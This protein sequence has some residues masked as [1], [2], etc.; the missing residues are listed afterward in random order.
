MRILILKPSSLGDIVCS[1]PVAQSIREQMPSAEISWVVKTRFSEILKRCSTVNG[2]ILE[3]Q[4]APGVK[5]L[6][7]IRT[8]MK[9]LRNRH[10]DV[11]LDFQGLL[12]TGLMT[13]SVNSP[14][15]VGSVEAREGSRLAYNRVV[16]LPSNGRESHAIEKLLQFL[17][18]IG[19]KPELRS[20]IDIEG[21]PL[22]GEAFCASLDGPI[23]MI[24]NSRG[25]HKEWKGFEELTTRLVN[26][27]NCPIVVWD[28]HIRWNTPP[29]THPERFVN[30][31]QR[32]SLLQLIE[33]IRTACLVVANDSGPLHIAAALGRPTL[34]IFGPT[35]PKRFGP[36]PLNEPRNHVIM[37]PDGDLSRLSADVVLNSVLAILDSGSEKRFAA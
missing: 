36:F 27:S 2:E 18:A 14:I 24:P 28:S 7:A 8:V 15:K 33:L 30:L 29:L 11:V 19:L 4:H 3:F 35:D 32:T 16:P 37:A 25:P 13:W 1:L 20:P 12:R 5:G 26:Q 21:D 22:A 31:T 6:M 17:P 10:F 23:V 9:S 34:G